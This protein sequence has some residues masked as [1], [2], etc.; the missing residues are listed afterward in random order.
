[1]FVRN[2]DNALVLTNSPAT[3]VQFPSLA[4]KTN[5]DIQVT[6][7]NFLLEGAL[8]QIDFRVRMQKSRVTRTSVIYINFPLYYTPAL[9]N[10]QRHLHCT[11][12]GVA[13]NCRKSPTNQFR[14]ELTNSPL[15]I[16]LAESFN[17]SVF[18][19]LNPLYAQRSNPLYTNETMFLAV[20]SGL[21][22]R[23][24]EFMHFRPPDV[25]P[26]SDALGYLHLH[27]VAVPVKFTGQFSRHTLKLFTDVRL[28][29]GSVLQILFP[30]DYVT[31]VITP[32]L[33]CALFLAD[34]G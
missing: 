26:T 13:I 21:P 25:Q 27:S 32:Q 17:L 29:L 31:M 22:D 30:P 5:S 23:Y 11:L 6:G 1:M 3:T 7:A 10:D 28:P 15:Q 4:E 14:L 9:T 8:G 18:G 34:P 2:F 20:D 24:S 33:R 16:S 19:I 12:N